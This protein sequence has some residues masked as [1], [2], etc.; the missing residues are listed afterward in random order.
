MLLTMHFEENHAVASSDF[1]DV[2]VVTLRG[3]WDV[4]N[5]ERLRDA[6]VALGTHAE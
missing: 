3:E 5:R 2:R 1:E 6:L 4:S